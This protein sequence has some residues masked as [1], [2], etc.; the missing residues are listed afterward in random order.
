MQHQISQNKCHEE[1]ILH[2]KFHAFFKKCTI[3]ALCRPT[4]TTYLIVC[5][6]FTALILQAY[7][8]VLNCECVNRT[9]CNSQKVSPCVSMYYVLYFQQL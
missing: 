6:N 3:L 4:I 8:G 9:D 1:Y 7:I 5:L 2:G